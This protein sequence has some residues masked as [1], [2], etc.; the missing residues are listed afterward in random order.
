MPFNAVETIQCPL[1]HWQFGVDGACTHIPATKEIPP[2]ARQTSYPVAVRHG[3]LH[4]FNAAE[5]LFPLPFFHDWEPHQLVAAPPFV[6]YLDCPWY[7]VGANA[8]DVQHFAIAHDRRMQR[9]PEVDHPHAHVHRTVC[10][11]EVH[12][13]ALADR[14]TRWERTGLVTGHQRATAQPFHGR[15]SPYD[16]R[17]GGPSARWQSPGARAAF[18]PRG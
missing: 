3:N 12:G 8:V 14:L 9:R 16:V 15:Q 4:V 10:H 1:H 5:P 11:F 6:E 7:M 13:S 18:V 17:R 2:F